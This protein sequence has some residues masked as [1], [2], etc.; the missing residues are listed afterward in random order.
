MSTE[1][2]TPQSIEELKLALAAAEQKLYEEKRA[3]AQAER[4]MKWK[5]EEDARKAAEAKAMLAWETTAKAIVAALKKV[6]F[7]NPTYVMSDSGKYPKILCF[8]SDSYP[9]WNVA[10]EECYRGGYNSARETKIKVG[11]Y[12]E[13]RT[14]PQ[15]KAGGFNYEK[16][17]ATAWEKYQDALA[18]RKR[19]NTEKNNQATNKRRIASLTDQ[20]G[21]LAYTGA[22][23]KNIPNVKLSDYTFHS[24]GRGHS[25]Y[26]Y[27]SDNDLMLD[28]THINEEDAAKLLQFMKENGMLE[29]K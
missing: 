9:A 24:D 7:A 27:R 6:G 8:S 20:F 18:K 2:T 17:A 25:S 21:E 12:G 13:S 28:I 23:Y 16:I 22:D 10:F 3:I 1:T 15:L 19:A 26:S 29:K 5:L 14:Y 4:E 11:Q